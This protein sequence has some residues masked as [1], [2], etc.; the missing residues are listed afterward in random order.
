MTTIR[1]FMTEDHRHCDDLFADAEQAIGQNNLEAALAALS[2]SIQ[3]S[4][5]ISIPRK[6]RFSRPLKP[7]PA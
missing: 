2:I 3:P 1:T 6:K 5:R 7:K 4:W